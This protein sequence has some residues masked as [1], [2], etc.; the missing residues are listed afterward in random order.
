[1][2]GAGFDWN[3]VLSDTR[4][5]ATSRLPLVSSHSA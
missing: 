5:S 2:E 4:G 1:V 3:D